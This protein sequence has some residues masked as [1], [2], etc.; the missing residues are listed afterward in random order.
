MKRT[1]LVLLAVAFSST[2]LGRTDIGWIEKINGDSVDVQIIRNSNKVD[3]IQFLAIQQGDN[4][5][6][7][8]GSTSVEISLAN[9]KRLRVDKST[10]Q[11]ALQTGAIPSL[12]GNLMNWVGSL[13][14]KEPNGNRIVTASTRNIGAFKKLSVPLLRD[15]TTIVAGERKLA[16]AWQG[17]KAPFEVKLVRL[18]TQAVEATF[19]TLA[20]NRLVETINLPPGTYELVVGDSAGASWHE[21]VITVTSSGLP[22]APAEFNVLSPSL[23]RVISAAW[24]SGIDDGKWALEAY[25]LIAA[26][27]QYS[28]ADNRL[29]QALEMGESP[30]IE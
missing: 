16:L 14:S 12:S 17:G 27:P 6:I 25:T 9:G 21:R 30:E 1:L 11:I 15:N 10:P 28:P 8:R 3:A 5:S 23:R 24:L 26:L 13:A 19:K 18:D 20:A 22:E 7:V 29:L 4:V 2:A